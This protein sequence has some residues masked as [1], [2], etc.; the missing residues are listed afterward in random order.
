MAWAHRLTR[1]LQLPGARVA[2]ARV[3]AGA[4]ATDKETMF[5]DHQ[6]VAR[7]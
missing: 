7:S 6:P 5:V 4:S 3:T 1:R 2:G